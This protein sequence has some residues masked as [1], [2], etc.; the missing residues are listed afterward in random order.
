MILNDKVAIV[1]G[2]A[3]GIGRAI[4]LGLAA[5]GAKVVVNDIGGAL[6]GS[7]PSTGPAEAVVREIKALGGNAIA[8]FESVDTMQGGKRIIETA[9]DAFGRLDTLACAAGIL[10]PANI[11]DMTEQEWDDVI[12]V[13]LKGHFAVMQPACHVMRKQQSGSIMTFT[14]NGGLEG[15]PLQPNYSAAKEGIIGL[16]RAVALTIAPYATCNAFWPSAWTRMTQRMLPPGRT[17]PPPEMTAPLAVFLASDAA[18]HITGQ[19]ITIS[20]EK[21]ALYP[22]PRPVRTAFRSGGWTA[23]ELA[24]VWDATLGSDQLVRYERY[25]PGKK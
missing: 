11:F 4:A 22:Q 19:V 23:E 15:N 21:V 6:D 13:H 8:C 1:T 25:F 16:T 2:A 24:R 5:A 14:S 10:R 7:S 20:G 12:R 18:R 9:L 3:G 17:S